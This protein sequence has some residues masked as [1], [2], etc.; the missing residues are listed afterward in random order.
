M[1]L[2]LGWASSSEAVV[3]VYMLV[4]ILN[5]MSAIVFFTCWIT[6]SVS[7]CD[8]SNAFF[9]PLVSFDFTSTFPFDGTYLNGRIFYC[10]AGWWLLLGSWL[11]NVF[12]SHSFLLFWNFSSNFFSSI[13]LSRDH[14]LYHLLR[15]TKKWNCFARLFAWYQFWGWRLTVCTFDCIGSALKV[16]VSLALPSLNLKDRGET[17]YVCIERWG[18][19]GII[20]WTRLYWF[21]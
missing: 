8:G 1:N 5:Q 7:L 3:E 11:L 13:V 19:I 17:C 21:N 12:L 20:W 10:Q 4:P 9:A 18:S 15:V 2:R 14:L 16:G 6:S